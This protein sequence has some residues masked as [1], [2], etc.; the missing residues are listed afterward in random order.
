MLALHRYAAE[1]SGAS[2]LQEVAELTFNAVEDVLS[3]QYG[4]FLVVE[5]NKL[6]NLL[7]RGTIN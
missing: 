4:S 3:Y 1:I 5:D 2:S 6:V 7:T